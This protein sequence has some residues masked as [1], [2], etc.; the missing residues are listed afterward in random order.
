MSIGDTLRTIEGDVRDFV[1]AHPEVQAATRALEE[2]VL[3][4]ANIGID[5]A[6]KSALPGL[7]S[8]LATTAGSIGSNQRRMPPC[9]AL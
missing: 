2:A 1:K 3:K 8:G 6:I 5:L 7:F 4:A 9:S